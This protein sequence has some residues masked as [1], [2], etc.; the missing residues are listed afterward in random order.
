MNTQ[1]KCL[2]R[3]RPGTVAVL[4]LWSACLALPTDALPGGRGSVGSVNRQGTASGSWSGTHSS[5]STSRSVSGDSSSRTTTA[6]GAGGETATGSRN[7][8]KSGDQVTVDRSAQSSTGAS[9]SSQKT[10]TMDDGHVESVDRSVQ[11]TNR[12]GESANWQGEANRSGAG[13]EFEGQGTNRYGEKV[14]AEGYGARGAYGT[15]RAV[16]VDGEHGDRTVVSGRYYGGPVYATTL[17]A[18]ARSHTYHGHTYYVHGSVHYTSYHYHGSVHYY[19]VPPPWGVVVTVVPVGAITVTVVGAS[20]YYADGVYYQMTYVQGATQYKVVV[21]PAGASIPGT[22]L[23]ADR[24]AI[25]LGGETFYLYGNTFYKRILVDGKESFV[26]VTKPTG[27]VTVKALPDDVEPLRKGNLLYFRSQG[28]HFVSYLDPG[29]EQLYVVVDAPA[30]AMPAVAAAAPAAPAPPPA[31]PAAARPSVTSIVV[32]PGTPLMARLAAEINSATAKPN[33]RFQGNL[34]ADLIVDGRVVAIRGSR[35]YG[36]VADAK[37]GTGTGGQPLLV[38]E[39]TDID[40]GGRIVA[41]ATDPN[42]FTAEGAKGGKKI[43]GG[44]VLG[45]G[46]GAIIDG[47]KGAGVGAVVGTAAGVA[48]AA[49][50]P[51]NQVSLTPGTSIKFQLARPFSVEVVG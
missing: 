33:E 24:A 42:R 10:Y 17:P 22:S 13:W 43:L 6:Q 23:P 14:S 8:S 34:D 39:L 41:I 2:L 36:R 26:V 45:A 28:R 25:T 3:P 47:S 32:A 30:G 19:Y 46:I 9:K 5:G 44:A 11:G 29:G 7:V 15:S 51:G 4:I 20:Y 21:P 12:Y 40:V 49:K 38:I 50:T 37:A 31:K 18:G 27:V 35:V 1:E 48:A 16:H